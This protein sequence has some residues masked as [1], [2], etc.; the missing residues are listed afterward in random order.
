MDILFKKSDEGTFLSRVSRGLFHHAAFHRAFLTAV[1]FIFGLGFTP[2]AQAQNRLDTLSYMRR[3]AS[4]RAAAL[5]RCGEY[6]VSHYT[7]LPD[8]EIP[9]YTIDAGWCRVPVGLRYRGGGI[10]YDDISAE[11]GLGWDLAAGGVITQEVRGMDDMDSPTDYVRRAGAIDK[12]SIQW[13]YE[14]VRRLERGNRG[15]L[16]TPFDAGGMYDGEHDLFR[17]ACPGGTGSFFFPKNGSQENTSITVDN[18]VF[19]PF[20]GWKADRTLSNGNTAIVL[21]DTEGT[22]YTFER[23]YSDVNNAYNRAVGEF[24]LTRIEQAG[25]GDAVTFSYSTGDYVNTYMT[26]PAII[27]TQTVS[28]QFRAPGD[29]GCGVTQTSPSIQSWGYVTTVKVF[30]PRLD[31]IDWRG[32]HMSFGYAS[33][34]IGERCILHV[35][36]SLHNRVQ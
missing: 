3:E 9:I 28:Q 19:V 29:Y 36:S 33:A 2:L 1:L 22:L 11:A 31:R 4:P 27:Y 25:T 16:E 10:R 21:T 15:T 14:A 32:G 30:T 7:G 6:P 18:T 8:I 12:T 35:G 26:K 34:V 13:D 23:L 5:L 24:Y 17:Y 20:N